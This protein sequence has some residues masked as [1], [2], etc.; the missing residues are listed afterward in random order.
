MSWV[1]ID[2]DTYALEATPD[3][4]QVVSLSEI[5]AEIASLSSQIK[6]VPDND[7]LEFYIEHHPN[8]TALTARL[9]NKQKLLEE[10]LGG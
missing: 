5:Q 2:D 10:I 8:Q 9:E 6:S 7:T 1:K 4:A 3:P